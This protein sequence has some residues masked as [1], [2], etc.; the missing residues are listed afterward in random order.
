MQARGEVKEAKAKSVIQLWMGGG[1]TPPR[2]LRPQARGR[3]RLLRP[4]EE[5]DR[6]QRAG[7]PD[8]RA[9]A[10]A[11]QAGRQ[12]LILRSFTH[13]DDGHETAAYTSPPGTLPTADLVYPSIGAVVALKKGYEAGYQ[14]RACRRTSR[15]PR[16]R[17]VL[18]PGFLGSKYKTFATGGDPNAKDFRVQGLTPAR[19]RDRQAAPGAAHACSSPSTAWPSRW[20]RTPL[21]Q[22]M[23][24]LPG[25]GL[26]PDPRRRQEGLRPVPGERRRARAVRPQPLRAVLPPGPPAGGARRAVHHR[27][28][29]AAGTRTPTISGP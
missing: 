17:P 9:A 24:H 10:A 6:H 16:P 5:P 22:T 25:A 13:R 14:G 21:F 19:R 11:G 23:R 28:L 2:H 29:W 1:P 4:A 15:S 20:T 12:V 18:R 26:R 3:R 7:D 27:Q 8:L